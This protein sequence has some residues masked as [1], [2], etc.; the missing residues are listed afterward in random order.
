M[1]SGDEIDAYLKSLEEA[2]MARIDDS[3]DEQLDILREEE[4][5][6]RTEFVY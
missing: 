3:L 6:N 4:S 5:Q 1:D 2:E